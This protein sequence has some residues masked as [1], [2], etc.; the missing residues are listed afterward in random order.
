VKVK[1]VTMPTVMKQVEK[2]LKTKYSLPIL[3]F[4]KIENGKLTITDLQFTV[5][6][7]GFK[8]SNG[9][10]RVIGGELTPYI[11][12]TD[13]FPFSPIKNEEINNKIGTDQN[14]VSISKLIEAAGFASEKLTHLELMSVMLSS[15]NGKLNIKSTDSF[16][17]YNRNLNI[18]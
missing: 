2:I 13:D 15:V 4:A 12:E 3:N 5:E 10:Y 8:E 7:P 16:R 9:L 6:V 18:N 14:G 17:G 11:T 1:E